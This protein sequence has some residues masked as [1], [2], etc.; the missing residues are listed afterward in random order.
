MPLG[1]VVSMSKS[2]YITAE[3]FYDFIKHFVFHKLNI[4]L[5]DGQS[6]HLSGIDTLQYT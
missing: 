2:G 3:I 6:M 4:F 5:L 1:T